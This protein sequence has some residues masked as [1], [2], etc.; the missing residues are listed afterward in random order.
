MIIIYHSLFKDILHVWMF[1]RSHHAVQVEDK[2]SQV[3]C[4]LSENTAVQ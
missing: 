1:W 2:E 4:E 3:D